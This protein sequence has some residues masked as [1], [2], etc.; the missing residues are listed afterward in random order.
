[1]NSV[2]ST[3]ELVRRTYRS[4]SHGSSNRRRDAYGRMLFRPVADN[5]DSNFMDPRSLHFFSTAS[6]GELAGGSP[7]TLIQ[8]ICTDSRQVQRGDLFIA[9]A[10]E[11]FDGHDFLF[12]VVA[13]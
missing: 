8:K 10:G 4:P 6:G 5:A 1:M 11:R 2:I 9:L 7:Q 3:T 13:K 12:E